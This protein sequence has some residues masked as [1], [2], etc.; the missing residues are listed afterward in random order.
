[1]E[2]WKYKD[3]NDYVESQ[4]FYNKAKLTW[5]YVKES[6]INQIAKRFPKASSV[7][8][9]GTR[10]GA[11]QKYFTKALPNAYVIGTEISDTATQFPMTVQQDFS[12]PREE[13]L[14]K[15]DII[16]SN[17]IDHSIDPEKTLTTWKNQLSPT[18]RLCI[19]YSEQQSVC[20]RADPL[21]ATNEEILEIVS[22]VGMRCVDSFTNNVTA[23]G[24]VFICEVV[25]D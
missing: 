24:V 12:E 15:F 10:N 25:H 4:T 1:M 16:Y 5:V 3:Y 19:E 20:E 18:G 23:G 11:E 7:L 13:F 17:S 2:I 22:K 14:N 9:H 21:K 6:T 8:C